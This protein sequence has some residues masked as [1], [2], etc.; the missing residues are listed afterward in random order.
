MYEL[1]VKAKNKLSDGGFNLRKC[2]SSSLVV[3]G[4]INQQ[5][6]LQSRLTT[7]DQHI[8]EDDESYAK[9]T[10]GD[11][12]YLQEEHKLLGVHWNTT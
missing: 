9:K 8:T 6:Q 11:E 2:V 4:R 5:E 1:I 7:S 10:L 3:Q 12:Q